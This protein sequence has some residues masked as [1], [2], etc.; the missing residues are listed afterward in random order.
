M[1]LKEFIS[2]S[3][4][5]IL[6]GMRAA[7]DGPDGDHVGAKGYFNAREAGIYPGGTSG[8]FTVVNFDIAVTA[9]TTEGG[10]TVRVAGVESIDGSLARASR[11]SR[12]KFAVQIRLPQGGD[13][14]NESN[15]QPG[16]IRSSRP[17]SF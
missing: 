4:T 6:Q 17:A 1:D 3:L 9:E 2:T 8:D 12:V 7:Q 14:T 10:G 16:R 15:S 5:Q 13:F 11:E